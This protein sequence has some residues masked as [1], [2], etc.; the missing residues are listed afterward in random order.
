MSLLYGSSWFAF[1]E[2]FYFEIET[3][4]YTRLVYI[5]TVGHGSRR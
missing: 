5:D 4:M 2:H 1:Y 3:A